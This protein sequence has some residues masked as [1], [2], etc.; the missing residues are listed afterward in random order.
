[1]AAVRAAAMVTVLLPAR[2]TPMAAT[3]AA[4]AVTPSAPVAEQRSR[5]RVATIAPVPLRGGS[6]AR[7]LAMQIRRAE[8]HRVSGGLELLRRLQDTKHLRV[9][10]STA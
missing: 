10:N 6:Q 2:M 7:G 4:A 3:V 8:S 5:H 1:M 9:S